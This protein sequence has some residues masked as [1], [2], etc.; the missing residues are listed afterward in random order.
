MPV[1]FT[2]PGRVQGK[3]RARTFYN[4]RMHKVMSMTPENTVNYENLIKVM[5]MQATKDNFKMFE[6]AVSV[7]INAIFKKSKSNKMDHA[8]L[9]PDLDNICKVC[10]DALNGLAYKDDKQVISVTLLKFFGE[11]EGLEIEIEEIK[12]GVA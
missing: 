3:A 6:G 9:K 2:V 12:E 1:K 5:F 8:M 11:P 4:P 10:L 7:T